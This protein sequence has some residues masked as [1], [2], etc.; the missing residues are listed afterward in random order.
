M[1]ITYRVCVPHRYNKLVLGQHLDDL[2]ESFIMSTLHN[3][4]VDWGGG[5]GT[6]KKALEKLKKI[7]SSEVSLNFVR[8]VFAAKM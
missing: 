3:G 5:G 1:F 7:K 4:Q 6:I 2:A 8:C